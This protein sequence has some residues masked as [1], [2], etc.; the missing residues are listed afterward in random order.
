MVT[1]RE[2]YEYL[3]DWAPF[4]T[5]L[6]FDN[7]GLLV[8]RGDGQVQR[9]LVSLD[10]TPEVALEGARLGAQ[11]IVSHHP[12]IFDPL[13]ALTDETMA[14]RAVLT[15][16]EHGIAA[17][18]AHTNLDAT[19]GGVNDMLAQALDLAEVI[20]LHPDGVDERG[21]VHGIGRVGCAHRIGLTAVEYAAFV[22]ERLAAGSVRLCDAGAPVRRVAVGG[23]S[24]GSMLADVAAA[25]CDTF[26]TAD[27]KY[28]V[29]LA[30]QN[31][32]INLIDAGHYATEQVVCPTLMHRLSRR[33]PELEIVQTQV[34]GEI[35]QSL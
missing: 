20:H 10:I 29:F 15:L 19:E 25:G 11:L 7:A 4:S 34:H 35:I 30:A 6:S 27:V 24:C 21:R 14:G 26:V 23:G 12:V 2:I 8:G 16:A 1:V 32:G 28:D 31:Q 17:L 22:K 33:F 13:R 18:C 5:Q 9:V 3:D